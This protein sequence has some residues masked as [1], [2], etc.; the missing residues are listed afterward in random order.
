MFTVIR[1]LLRL[2]KPRRCYNIRGHDH[3]NAKKSAE[4]KK[5]PLTTK[6]RHSTAK[7]KLVF[8]H[9]LKKDADCFV[10]TRYVN[11]DISSFVDS[12]ACSDCTANTESDQSFDDN[13][14]EPSRNTEKMIS[15]FLDST[16]SSIRTSVHS[17]VEAY[18]EYVRL[19]HAIKIIQKLSKESGN[20]A[21][22]STETDE[23]FMVEMTKCLKESTKKLEKEYPRLHS[24]A[25]RGI[26]R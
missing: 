23:M 3:L 24:Y 25:H 22:L 21:G 1:R 26:K 17:T 10:G 13:V 19:K 6:R 12:E 16:M 5:L 4:S 9:S 15:K 2:L 20:E 11:G 8:K 7:P 14:E 18:N